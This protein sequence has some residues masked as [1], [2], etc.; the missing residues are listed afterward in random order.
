MSSCYSILENYNLISGVKLSI[1]LFY[2][3]LCKTTLDNAD[4]SNFVTFE[5]LIHSTSCE[6]NS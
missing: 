5:S 1:R 4:V 3:T 2:F 6:R